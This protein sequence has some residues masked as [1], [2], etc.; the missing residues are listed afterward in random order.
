MTSLSPKMT[1]IFPVYNVELYLR[2]C[3]DSVINQ[4]MREIQII[5]V[6]DGSTD[7]SRTILQEYANR[8]SRL[9]IIDQENQGAGSARNAGIPY[10][11]GK[12]V[13][14][15]DPDDWMESTLCEKTY[16]ILEETEADA[17]MI[18]NTKG[19]EILKFYMY[20]SSLPRIRFSPDEKRD[21]LSKSQ[22]PWRKVWNSQFLINNRVFFCKTNHPTNDLVQNWR[23]IGQAKKIVV[24][25]E[26]LYHYSVRPN[27]YQ[28]NHDSSH[29]YIC[30][31]MA[32][33]LHFLKEGR[34]YPFY[35]DIYHDLKLTLFFKKYNKFSNKLQQEFKELIRAS[36]TDEDREFLRSEAGEMLPKKTR[37][38][39]EMIDGGI[40]R[41]I[42]YHFRGKI[43]SII[44][45]PEQIIRHA[46]IKPLKKR[47]KAA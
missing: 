23:G 37:L 12:Y 13:Y 44:K 6:N 5:C 1:L 43:T 18:N 45:A 34:H 36:L 15:A 8:D 28:Q 26:I 35:R 9:E 33:L 3:L 22:A 7:G 29:F 10:I 11:K 2:Q 42:K 20:N 39:Y 31:R 14:F 40:L 16:G 21:L 47:L 24:L 30:K 17:V 41:T 46:I 25:D 19:G 27:S 32:D 4:T 38:F